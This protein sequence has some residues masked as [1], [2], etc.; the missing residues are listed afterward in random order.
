MGLFLAQRLIV[1]MHEGR[2]EMRDRPGGG[3]VAELRL[4]L[5]ENDGAAG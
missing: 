1:G 4:Q 3:T 2:L 5:E